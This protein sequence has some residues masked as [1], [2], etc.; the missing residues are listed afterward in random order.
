MSDF[1]PGPGGNPG[2]SP[3]SKADWALVALAVAL[4]GAG[5]WFWF[6]RT[7]PAPPPPAPV[8]A[9]P[10]PAEPAPTAPAPAAPTSAGLPGD[11]L[12][13]LLEAISP[14]QLLRG[15]LTSGDAVERWAVVTDNLAEGASP[16]KA[17]SFLEP[18]KPFAVADRDGAVVIAP[19]SYRRYDA[20]ADAVASVDVEGAARAYRGLHEV[21][22]A[23]YR[24]LGYPGASLDDVTAKALRRVAGAP[25]AEKEIVLIPA[26][27]GAIWLF[28]DP[29]LEQLTAVEKHLLRMG[30]RNEKIVQA[31]A[32]EL[33]KAL[34]M[35]AK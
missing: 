33:L 12:K 25:V 31:K 5:A 21:L 1:E 32:R 26:P 11:R 10:A 35:P 29:K 17:L 4:V 20:I 24:A 9:A 13:A 3:M 28:A 22:Q 14:S 27:E 2:R 8:A 19:E 34:G 18:R 6:T 15:W 30:P 7:P 23:A 16:R